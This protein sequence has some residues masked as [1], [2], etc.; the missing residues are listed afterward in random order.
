MTLPSLAKFERL[1]SRLSSR[2]AWSSLI[3][4]IGES[5]EGESY[6]SSLTEKAVS[7]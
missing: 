4:S 2:R 6:G 5:I 3:W 1:W 7:A